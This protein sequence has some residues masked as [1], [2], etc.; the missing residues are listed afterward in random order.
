LLTDANERE[1]EGYGGGVH[2]L[3]SRFRRGAAAWTAAM[4]NGRRAAS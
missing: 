4:P 3:P 1:G 2:L